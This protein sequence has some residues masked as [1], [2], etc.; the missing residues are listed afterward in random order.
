[1]SRLWEKYSWIMRNALKFNEWW[2]RWVHKT[3]KIEI[4][5]RGPNN[6]DFVQNWFPKEIS[7]PLFNLCKF[8][9]SEKCTPESATMHWNLINDKGSGSIKLSKLKYGRGDKIIQTLCRIGSPKKL[10]P[11]SLICRNLKT[12][13]KVLLNHAECIEI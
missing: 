5:K 8:Q 12:L 6:S 4:Q 1:M 2:R 3:F 9:D 7:S 13:S 11:P 10:A